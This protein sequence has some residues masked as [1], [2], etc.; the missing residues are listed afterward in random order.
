[1]EMKYEMCG[2]CDLKGAEI[3]E[4]ECGAGMLIGEIPD[5]DVVL[6]AEGLCLVC[7]APMPAVSEYIDVCDK[8]VP[9]C[10]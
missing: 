9:S 3:L 2:D 6:M 1:M 4:C 7:W 10:R 5:K 8:C